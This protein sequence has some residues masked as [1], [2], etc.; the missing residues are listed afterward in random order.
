VATIEFKAL[1]EGTTTLHLSTL[2]IASPGGERLGY[3]L[4]DSIVTVIDCV[5]ADINRDGIVD[6]FDA[7]ILAGAFNSVLGSPSW[8]PDAD[9]NGD[10][11]IDIYDAMLLANHY[12]QHYP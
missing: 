7:L 6:I 5:V 4:Y 3:L 2:I 11:V 10:N 9:I 8:K 1:G 12:N